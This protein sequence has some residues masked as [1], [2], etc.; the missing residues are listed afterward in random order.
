MHNKSMEKTAVHHKDVEG[1]MIKNV[2]VI[3]GR[4]A[5][6]RTGQLGAL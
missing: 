4:S 5:L 6:A 3:N 1:A 2:E